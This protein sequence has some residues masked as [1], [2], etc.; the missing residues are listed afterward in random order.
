MKVINTALLTLG[1]I[2]SPLALADHN[3]IWGEGWASM[4]NDI[5]DTRID[6]LDSDA[7]GDFI[8]FVSQGSGASGDGSDM[9]GGNGGGNGRG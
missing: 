2:A 3:S 4:P 8:D 9:S 7:S 6:T 5:H 1:L